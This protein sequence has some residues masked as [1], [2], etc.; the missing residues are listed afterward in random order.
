MKPETAANSLSEAAAGSE[1][2]RI[3]PIT[4]F[5][6]LR[7]PIRLKL[8]RIMAAGRSVSATEASELIHHNVNMV[9][10]HFRILEKS[11]FV[12]LKRSLVDARVLLYYIPPAYCPEPNLLKFDFCVINLLTIPDCPIRKR[13]Q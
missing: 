2:S 3:D 4:L 5:S 9:I 12:S 8:V 6:A 7:H 1:G 10:Q 11:G 13:R